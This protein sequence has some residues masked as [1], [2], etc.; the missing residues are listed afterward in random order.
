MAIDLSIDRK[1]F[2]N[3]HYDIPKKRM[4]EM[5]FKCVLVSPKHIL[6]IIL[7]DNKSLRSVKRFLRAQKHATTHAQTSFCSEKNNFL[8]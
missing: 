3:D 5:Q 8:R 6:K 2:H 7:S 1:W 4:E